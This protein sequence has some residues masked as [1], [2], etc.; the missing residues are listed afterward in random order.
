MR[1]SRIAAW[2]VLGGL[3]GVILVITVLGGAALSRLDSE[4]IRPERISSNP[5]LTGFDGVEI[6]GAWRVRVIQGREWRVDLSYPEHLEEEIES[7]V[8]GDRLRLNHRKPDHRW[9]SPG[10]PVAANIIMPELEELDF[11]G[12]GRVAVSGFRGHR[13]EIIVAGAI[14]LEGRDGRYDELDLSAA[15]A[16]DI[17]LQGIV[18]TD[19]EVAVAGASDV[20]LTMDGGEL[21]G[22]MAGWGR[23]EY[24]GPVAAEM[25][26]FAGFGRIGRVE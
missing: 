25:I 4:A 19:A 22:S 6:R 23:I 3:A 2:S 15:G 7:Y 17:D 8:L 1:P 18:V 26:D 12:T 11:K 14:R 5:D 20:T 21:S 10:L 9:R 13:I 24:Y 16:S